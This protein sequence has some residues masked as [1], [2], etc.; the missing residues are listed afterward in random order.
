MPGDG[1][2]G[3]TGCMDQ[4]HCPACGHPFSFDAASTAPPDP[5]VVDWFRTD[6][7][8]GEAV[9]TEEA[10]QSYLRAI[11]TAPVSRARFVADLA[12]LGVEQVLDDDTQ[13]L[14]RT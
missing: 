6:T 14:I 12:Y 2:R 8:W 13:M 11:N 9:S 7:G 5:T 10:Y 1:R 3:Q 4:I